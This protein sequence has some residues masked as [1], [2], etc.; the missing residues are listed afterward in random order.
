VYA[1]DEFH[2]VQFLV[3]LTAADYS[4]QDLLARALASVAAALSSR[5]ALDFQNASG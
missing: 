3:T 2:A 1:G 4:K 5:R